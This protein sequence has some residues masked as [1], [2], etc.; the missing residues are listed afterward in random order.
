VAAVG[1]IFFSLS[2]LLSAAV[3]ALNFC[4]GFSAGGFVYVAARWAVADTRVS[5]GRDGVL[6]LALHGRVTARQS[7]VYGELNRLRV[8]VHN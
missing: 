2:V 4:D 6:P 1:Q 3:M 8:G 5:V 7:R